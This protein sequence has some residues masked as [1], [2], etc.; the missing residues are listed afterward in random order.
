M[1]ELLNGISLGKIR[2]LVTGGGRVAHGAMETLEKL[3]IPI[4]SPSEYLANPEKAPLI[5]RIDPGDYVKKNTDEAFDFSDFIKNPE[6]YHS[7]FQK[8]YPSTDLLISAHFWDPRSPK[9]FEEEEMKRENFRIRVIAD[10][11]CDINGSIPSTIRATRIDDPYYDWNPQACKE[12]APFSGPDYIT[13]MTIDNLPG[14][15]PRDASDEFA[16]VLT[17][18]IMPHLLGEDSDGVICRATIT[19][20]GKLTEQFKY[21]E[22]FLSESD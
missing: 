15:L 21:L 10:I 9:L 7:V 1:D 2:I 6:P 5:C 18:N 14:E 19:W 20:K 16:G 17:R 22:D 8:F 13:M 12:E 4:V 11:S 3:G